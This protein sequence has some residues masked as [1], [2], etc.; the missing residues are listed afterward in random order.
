MVDHSEGFHAD[1]HAFRKGHITENSLSH[2][3]DAVESE[4][5]K[6][7]T[8]SSKPGRSCHKAGLKACPSHKVQATKKKKK[9]VVLK[10]S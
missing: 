4:I 9:K 6:G 1:Q 2:M 10:L 8:L 5:L 3:A 7:D